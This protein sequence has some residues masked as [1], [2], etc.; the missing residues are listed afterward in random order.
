MFSVALDILT[1]IHHNSLDSDDH[2]EGLSVRLVALLIGQ[3]LGL[4]CDAQA[5]LLSGS[6]DVVE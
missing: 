5:G 6:G 2:D 3:S 1:H 4:S